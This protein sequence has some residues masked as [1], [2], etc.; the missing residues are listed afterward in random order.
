MT[1]LTIIEARVGCDFTIAVI[2]EESGILLV[3]AAER[4]PAVAD[5]ETLHLEINLVSFPLVDR[6][7]DSKVS[8]QH[9]TNWVL[10][11]VSF[12]ERIEC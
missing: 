10:L 5:A 8:L 7:L 6:H 11:V 1:W 3:P 12:D 2:L 4:P 9:G